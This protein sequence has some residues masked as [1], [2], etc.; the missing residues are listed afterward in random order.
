[1]ARIVIDAREY[2]TS[3]GYY[4][5]WLLENLKKVDTTNDYVILMK[6]KDLDLFETTANFTKRAADFREFTFLDEQIRFWWFL[7]LHR[8]WLI[9]FD[10]RLVEVTDDVI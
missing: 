10:Y 2:S 8:L 5:K 9:V 1:M 4:T 6:S 3:T 7:T